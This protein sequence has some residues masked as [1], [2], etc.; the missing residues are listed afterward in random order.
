MKRAFLTWRGRCR[1]IVHRLDRAAE[2]INPLLLIVVVVLAL[3]DVSCFTALHIAQQHPHE[4][5]TITAIQ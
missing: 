3:I 2:L 1:P 5:T 4:I